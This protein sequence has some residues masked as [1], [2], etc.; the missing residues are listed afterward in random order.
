MKWLSILVAALLAAVGISVLLKD[1]TGYVMLTWGEWTIETSLALFILLLLVLFA[2]AYLAV[3]ALI[4]LWQVP[5]TTAKWSVERRKKKNLSNIVKGHV[6]LAEGQWQ[7]A[8]KHLLKHV[9]HSDTP[10]LNYLGA[11]QAAQQQGAIERRDQ[12]L[13]LAYKEDKK[14]ALAVQLTQAEL[15]LAEG[16]PEQAQ[17][18]LAYLKEVAPKHPRVLALLAQVYRDLER[19]DKLRELLPVLRRRHIFTEEDLKTLEQQTFLGILDRAVGSD[20]EKALRE[21]WN[22]L[23]KDARSNPVLVARYASTLA[24]HKLGDEAEAVLRSALRKQWAPELVRLYG[25]IEGANAERQLSIAESWLQA[26]PKDA[27]LL[28]TLGKLALRDQEWNKAKS[29]L[30]STLSV[31]PNA[32]ACQLLAGLLEQQGDRERAVEYYREGMRLALGRPPAKAAVLTAP[33]ETKA[34][35]EKAP[36]EK[37]SSPKPLPSAS[38]G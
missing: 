25:D 23:P 27:D 31:T 6:E 20:D 19:W 34:I 11:A 15:Q 35:E 2:I 36:G 21:A 22:S 18:T 37:E 24:K 3:R 5:R 1:E 17:K 32:E 12:Y 28:L 13:Q 29:Y 9:Q 30:E 14:A 10:L 38:E 4:R 8:E 16:N 7:A 26:H 33:E